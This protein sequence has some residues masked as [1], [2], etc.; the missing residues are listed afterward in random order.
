MNISSLV[1]R[2][3]LVVR[4]R[5]RVAPEVAEP[6]VVAA[7][8][9]LEGDAGAHH[10]VGRAALEAV[11]QE[12]HRA[13]LP[14]AFIGG[15]VSDPARKQR[16]MKFADIKESRHF[17]EDGYPKKVLDTYKLGRLDISTWTP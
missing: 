15:W 1:P 3:E 12:G 7:P 6:D 2:A 8:R 16:V 13:G 11:L 9:E 5:V 10:E 4:P 17:L 14:A